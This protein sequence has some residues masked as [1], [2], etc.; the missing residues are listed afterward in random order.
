MLSQFVFE[1]EL[2]IANFLNLLQSEGLTSLTEKREIAI[3]LKDCCE[4]DSKFF[5]IGIYYLTGNI[6]RY[7]VARLAYLLDLPG[8]AVNAYLEEG[9]L[10]LKSLNF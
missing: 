4:E 8:K 7:E 6:P 3:A 5:P 1:R 10:V 2:E 9:R